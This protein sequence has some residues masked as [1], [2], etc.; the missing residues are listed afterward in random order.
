MSFF[1]TDLIGLATATLLGV[2]LIVAP[3]FGLTRLALPRD[4]DQ[5]DGAAWS[6]VSIAAFL[7][8]LFALLARLIALEATIAAALLLG[9]AGLQPLWAAVRRLPRGVWIWLALWWA[10]IAY[11]YCDIDIGGR[12]NQSMVVVDLVKHA[13]TVSTIA[14]DG[15][16]LHDPFVNRPGMSGYYYYFYVAGA[17]LD[18]LGGA[19]VDPREAFAATAF[20]TG[21]TLPALLWLL[22]RAMG[23]VEPGRT[24]AFLISTMLLFFVSGLDMPMML[25]RY[26]LSDLLESQA[27]RWG[28]EISFANVAV[29]WVPHHFSAV[30]ASFAALL[31][32]SH[33]QTSGRRLLYAAAAAAL[34][35][36]FGLS[37]WIAIG[38]AT[39][40][41]LWMAV[42]LVRGI[43]LPWV[44]LIACGAI[45]LLLCVPQLHDLV[46]GRASE[47]F[48]LGFWIRPFWSG[49]PYDSWPSIPLM[50]LSWALEFGVYALGSWWF[51]RNHP[52]RSW[53]N[54]PL[55]SMLIVAVVVGLLYNGFVRSTVLNN[56]FGWR[57]VWFAQI[58][59]MLWTALAMHRA[60]GRFTALPSA[61][62]MLFV[63]LTLS[64]YIAPA[65]RLLRGDMV[66]PFQQFMN[67]DQ[68]DDYAL[69]QAYGWANRHIP[70][71]RVLQHNPVAHS[72]VFDFGL[73]GVH[74]VAVA[75]KA[76]ILFGAS[77]ALVHERIRAIAPIFANRRTPAEI[78]ETA[79]AID[80]DYL[81]IL[82]RDPL[83]AQTGG[84]RPGLRCV[85]RSP[86]VCITPVKD[87]R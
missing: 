18:R 45:A 43:A 80:I 68:E 82:H 32:L 44:G 29:T 2:L 84:E 17:V 30:V 1:L 34:A 25:I 31:L 16:P 3:G 47:G 76:A 46:V 36:T 13:L 78:G 71:T 9:L 11:N 28:D 56:D 21:L 69:R 55:G 42:T 50:P 53:P 15:L 24:R 19:I 87:L 51:L 79:R 49:P 60:D 59:A 70:H 75:D 66:P 64:L 5:R 81:V 39:V 52:P 86:T 27:D 48:P 67:N 72:R 10:V 12:L 73:Y 6:L 38:V 14:R 61:Q 77:R 57:V 23:W 65:Y 83:W 4:F 54:V 26:G 7:P 8:L 62:L 22:G 74:R 58:P 20:F 41:L 37:V 33:A 35:A 40:I 85:Y 63:G